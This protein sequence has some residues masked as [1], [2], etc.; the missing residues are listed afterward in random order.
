MSTKYITL[1]K[2]NLIINSEN[3]PILYSIIKQF[4]GSKWDDDHSVWKVPV[5]QVEIVV[6]S[7]S[8]FNFIIDPAVQE[9]YNNSIKLRAKINRILEGRFKDS[10][11]A[12]F[13]KTKLPLVPF[14]KIGAGFMLVTGSC[15]LA[16]E[17]GCGKSIQSIAVVLIREAK[18]V[19]IVCPATL[20]L[21]WQEEI[22]KWT[23]D[24]K[25]V[26]IRGSK[27]QR[28]DGWNKEATYYLTTYESLSHDFDEIIKH[29]WDYKIS[30]ESS[31]ISNV[32]A[33]QSKVIKKIPAE[34]NIA[35]TG[36]PV[37][38]GVEDIWNIVDFCKPNFLGDYWSFLNRYVV[39]QN[40]TVKE[41]ISK[42][43]KIIP[44]RNVSI[45]SGYKNLPEL[46]ERLKTIM[47]RRKKEDVLKDLPPVTYQNI[48]IEFSKEEKTMY[49][50][51][52]ECITSELKN[53]TID[54]AYINEAVVKLLR[55]QQVCD[56]LEL[57][58]ESKTSSKL[59][60]LKEKL[61]ELMF[62]GSKAVLF[63]H[64]V[65][66]VNILV[67]ELKEYNP[68]VITG[69]VKE[70][71]RN[72]NKNLFIN[73]DKYKLMIMSEAGSLGLNF[74][75]SKKAK[76]MINYDKPWSIGKEEQRHGRLDRFGQINNLTIYNMVVKD[77]SFFSADEYTLQVLDRKGKASDGVTGDLEKINKV[78][79][80][81]ADINKLLK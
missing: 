19:L 81:K 71:Q 23:P 57:I 3:N 10:E 39:K 63:T 51:V 13:E 61:K 11:I 50:N 73:D 25:S 48:Y 76:Y 30:D 14:Q 20:K 29:K 45:V 78:K 72:I 59:E 8:K 26:V 67:R 9:E 54:T 64:F 21:S 80:S 62:D 17:P 5:S 65:P 36:T 33:T 47:L 27:K 18:Q 44:E 49:R 7:L 58:S 68:L 15:L 32:T 53:L 66:M 34:H 41:K 42:E 4:L 75:E 22:N 40:I 43:G 52:Q 79:I 6:D 24:L 56:S 16:D 70:Q 77:D 37:N 2:N 46:R 38:N 1:Y 69:E 35:L 60:A 31:R 55:L 74:Q 12:L 28:T